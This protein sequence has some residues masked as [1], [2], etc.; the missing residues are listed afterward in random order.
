MFHAEQRGGFSS[1]LQ[2]SQQ[3]LQGT[4]LMF[5]FFLKLLEEVSSSN[6]VL[7]PPLVLVLQRQLAP[8]LT[9]SE[10]R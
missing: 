10:T 2:K 6:A 9:G 3:G 1:V 4:G 7:S 8:S 5:F